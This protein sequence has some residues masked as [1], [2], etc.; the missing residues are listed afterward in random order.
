V[1][2]PPLPVLPEPVPQFSVTAKAKKHR[3]PRRLVCAIGRGLGKVIGV[4]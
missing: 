2:L 3:W 4:R 1:V